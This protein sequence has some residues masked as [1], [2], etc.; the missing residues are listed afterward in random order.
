LEEAM[1]K[2]IALVFQRA[3]Y[4]SDAD[5]NL[6]L[7]YVNPSLMATLGSAKN[8]RLEVTVYNRS[9]ANAR[10]E[11]TVYEG[12]K[13]DPRPSANKFSGAP[14]GSPT[15]LVVSNLYITHYQI[16]SPFD[17]LVDV[18]LGVKSSSPSPGVQEFMDAEVRATLEFE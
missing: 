14:I 4:T 3:R 8:L 11:L 12:T 2:R 13:S 18:T 6:Q 15:P 9:S 1:M 17:G 10:L 7:V 16:N 5:G